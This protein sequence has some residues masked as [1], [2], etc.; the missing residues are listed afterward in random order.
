MLSLVTS[1]K[2]VLGGKSLIGS[3]RLHGLSLIELLI[4]LT[5]ALVAFGVVTPILGRTLQEGKRG[6]DLQRL[7]QLGLAAVQ[8][9]Q[10]GEHSPLSCSDLIKLGVVESW[11]CSSRADP[12]AEGFANIFRRQLSSRTGMTQ[13]KPVPYRLSFA[14]PSDVGAFRKSI[15]LG[16]EG[17]TGWLIDVSPSSQGRYERVEPMLELREGRYRRLLDDGAVVIR[18]FQHVML[19]KNRF[20]RKRCSNPSWHFAD[21][22]TEEIYEQCRAYGLQDP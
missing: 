18:Q 13:F 1:A 7:R 2:A 12:N 11:I 8:Y 17:S 15:E 22:S 19:D 4:V 16:R 3:Q 5:I 6:D 20:P 21:F 10:Q 14:G 9:A